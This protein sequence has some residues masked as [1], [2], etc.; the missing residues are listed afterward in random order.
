M[1]LVIYSR[2]GPGEV[3]LE[4]QEDGDVVVLPVNHG[5]GFNDQYEPLDNEIN[6]ALEQKYRIYVAQHVGR[7]GDQ[8]LVRSCGQEIL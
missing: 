1:F 2:R 6:Y 8:R 4:E 3:H 7:H 5:S